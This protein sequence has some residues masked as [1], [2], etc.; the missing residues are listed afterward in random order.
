VVSLDSAGNHCES[1]DFN[2]TTLVTGGKSLIGSSGGGGGGS[3]STIGNIVGLPAVDLP[4]SP[5]ELTIVSGSPIPMTPDNLVA[6]PVVV[7]SGD[8]SASLSIDANTQLLDREGQPVSSIDL[9]RIDSKDVPAIP[10]GS[11]FIFSGYA[12][13]IEPSGATFSPPIV[14]KIT[15]TPGEW[16]QI[17]GQEL[18]IQYYNPVTGLWEALSTTT[19]P[20][21]NSVITMIAHS[22][23]YGLF[24][25]P[26]SP[27]SPHSTIS[28]RTT[29]PP[30]GPV[31]GV[32]GGFDW[33]LVVQGLAL[34]MPIVVAASIGLLLYLKK[35]G[36]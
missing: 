36:R 19:D 5:P 12:Y 10:K 27:V 13:Q 17:S 24:I 32:P 6:E 35:N 8:K 3:F 22:S 7:V 28:A 4:I 1:P 30:S 33:I 23:D 11:L 2:F 14:L 21:T 34:I 29:I 15:T 26:V 9:T 25:R 31:H 20:E 16:K 18:S